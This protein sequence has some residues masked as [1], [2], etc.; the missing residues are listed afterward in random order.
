M[1]TSSDA[2]PVS[3]STGSKAIAAVSAAIVVA[4]IAA[5]S[6]IVGWNARRS[7]ARSTS[8]MPAAAAT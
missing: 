2:P 3:A 4:P 5:S 7:R 1:A 6:H 8:T